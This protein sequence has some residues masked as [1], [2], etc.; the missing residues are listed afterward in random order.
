MNTT[1]QGV[2]DTL[3]HTPDLCLAAASCR[4]LIRAYHDSPDHVEWSDVDMAFVLALEAFG[5]SPESDADPLREP[6][7]VQ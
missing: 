4:A 3:A 2:V 6:R 7:H 5:I 1:H